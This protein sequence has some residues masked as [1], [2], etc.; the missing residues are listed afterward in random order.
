[1]RRGRRAGFTLIELLVVIVMIGIATAILVPRVRVSA[2][3]QV[4]T[5]ARQLA[6]DIELVRMRAVA[7]SSRARIVFD[8]ANRRYQAYLDDDRDGTIA[9]SAAER[10]AMLVLGERPLP[11]RIA[12][13][14]GAAGALPGF[15]G[16]GAITLPGSRLDFD[17]RGLVAPL[18]TRG[19]L[20][21]QH[22]Q[23]AAAQGAVS[24]E[25][26]A[27]TRTWTVVGGTWH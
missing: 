19:A 24:I 12:F 3:R 21:L 16:P 14:R 26:S 2:D 27:A 23:Q 8:E 15:A 13:A 7:T 6:R 25:G 17:E 9:E 5:A 18:G 20:Y 11:E 22:D 10:Q 1:M 4:A